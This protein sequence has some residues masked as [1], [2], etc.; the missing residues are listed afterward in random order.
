MGYKAFISQMSECVLPGRFALSVI[1]E[2]VRLLMVNRHK[3]AINGRS[4]S[5]SA[6]HS[7]VRFTQLR[8]VPPTILFV[9]S[10]AI[11]VIRVSAL[12]RRLRIAF[13]PFACRRMRMTGLTTSGCVLATRSGRT[14]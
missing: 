5:D 14:L 9:A 10:S 8:D 2:C 6:G 3:P 4:T 12:V 7:K 11:A 13:L 1:E